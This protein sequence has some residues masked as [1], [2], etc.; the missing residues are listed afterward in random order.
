MPNKDYY[1][2]LGVSKNASADDVKKAFRK[3]AHE[4]H[5]DKGGSA[6]KFKEINEAYQVLGNA[7]KRQQYDRFGSSFQHGQ[8]GGANGFGGFGQG[9]FSQGGFSQGGVNFDFG[10]LGE[11]F[12]LGDM[13]GFGGG[14]KTARSGKTRGHDLEMTLAIDFLEAVFGTEKEIQYKK[15]IVCKKCGG[16]GAEPGSKIETCST[17]NGHG[18][19]NQVQRTILGAMQVETVCPTCRGEGKIYSQKCSECGGQGLSREAVKLKVKIP[20]GIN[21][22]ESIR[23]TGQ[24]DAGSKG[25]A[26]GDLFLHISVNPHKKFSRAEYDIKIKEIVSIKQ[27]IL[28]DSIS[29]ETVDGPLK[30]KIPAGTQS[31]TVFRLREKGVPHLHNRQR[32]DELVEIIVN[33][34]KNLNKKDAKLIEELSL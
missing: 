28:G 30:L 31:G 4:H 34:P 5:P 20:A 23:L 15:I 24:G 32:G 7:D 11:M 33:I 16:G 21:T 3:L 25:G 2:V 10:D 27:A 18:R 17:C 9:G 12:D 22:G 19:V 29:V 14:R 8:A 13:F 26:S 1:E 6:E